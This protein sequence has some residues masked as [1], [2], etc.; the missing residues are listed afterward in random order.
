VRYARCWYLPVHEVYEVEI[1]HEHSMHATVAGS[2]RS[3]MH[4]FVAF[5]LH[6]AELEAVS[7]MNCCLSTFT[8]SFTDGY[9]VVNVC[10]VKEQP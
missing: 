3:H 2:I 8:M 9:A 1:E 4:S 5:Y 10:V 7:G 6:K